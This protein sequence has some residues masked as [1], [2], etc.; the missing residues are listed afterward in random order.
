MEAKRSST[1]TA[2][3]LQGNWVKFEDQ[4]LQ[5]REQSIPISKSKKL[6][7]DCMNKQGVPGKTQT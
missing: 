5:S 4:L 6:Q 3:L 1:P 7:E 2:S